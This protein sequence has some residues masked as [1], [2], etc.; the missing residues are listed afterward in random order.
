[1]M[2]AAAA[3]ELPEG[4]PR[5]DQP[6][7]TVKTS[8]AWLIDHAGFGKGYGSGSVTLSTKHALALTNRGGAKTTDLLTLARE[9]R[10][11]VEAKFGVTLTNEPVLVGCSL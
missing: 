7:G 2:S 3:A 8:A 4:A 1:M 10:A 6:D 9:V 5:F 11:G